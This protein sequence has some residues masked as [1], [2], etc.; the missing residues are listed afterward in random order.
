M[1][2]KATQIGYYGHL[3][4]RA[5]DVFEL[6]PV[7]GKK[8][9]LSIEEQ[10]SSK[11]MRKLNE[12]Q[13]A[14]FEAEQAEKNQLEDEDLE[15][16][17]ANDDAEEMALAGHNAKKAAEVASKPVQLT[18]AQKAAATKAAKAAKKADANEEIVDSSEA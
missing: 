12:K 15:E 11:W 2:V 7:K 8:V 6:K 5:G 10:F 9:T 4:R 16:G 17:S 14:Q 18:K 13:I 3:R 1:L